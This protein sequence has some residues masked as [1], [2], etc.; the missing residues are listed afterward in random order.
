MGMNAGRHPLSP[1]ENPPNPPFVKGG[2]GGFLVK[3]E[4]ACMHPALERDSRVDLAE[5]D[6]GIWTANTGECNS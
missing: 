3:V 4:G 6:R 1:L 5:G 2:Q